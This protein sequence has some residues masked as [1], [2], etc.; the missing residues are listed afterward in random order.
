MS[1]WVDLHLDVLAS[2]P[3][4]ISQIERALQNPCDELIAW[5]AQQCGE[6]PKEIAG[7][8][9]E[10]VSFKPVRNLGYVDPSVNKARRFEN[11]WKDRFWGLVWSHV[12]FVSRD[13][14]S[15]IFLAQHW[16]DQMSYGGK[17]VFHAGDEIRSSYDGDHRAQG[18]E[19]VSPNIFAPFKAEH[20]LGLECG[21]LWDEWVEG[22]RRQIAVLTE[23][24][25]GASGLEL[26]QAVQSG[27][28]K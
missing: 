2:C 13:Y 24:H 1:N 19:W 25:P 17:R 18:R 4:E 23:R 27:E 21:S 10:I 3:A 7:N 22:M 20:E 6:A 16:D 14:P 8:V 28:K 26:K 12:F 11:E 9:K 15:A 5:R